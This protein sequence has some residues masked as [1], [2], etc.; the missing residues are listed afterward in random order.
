MDGWMSAVCVVCI[1]FWDFM[2]V[3]KSFCL[4]IVVSLKRLNR[5][6]ALLC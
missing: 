3:E 5:V 6:G 1:L 4:K 2:G